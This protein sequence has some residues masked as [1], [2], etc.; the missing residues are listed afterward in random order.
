MNVFYCLVKKIRPFKYSHIS[1]FPIFFFHI[2][3]SI[4]PMN[5]EVLRQTELNFTYKVPF[6]NCPV[7]KFG[8]DKLKRGYCSIPV[9]ECLLYFWSVATVSMAIPLECIT[10]LSAPT[11]ET[12]SHRRAPKLD[13]VQMLTQQIAMLFHS[14]GEVRFSETATVHIQG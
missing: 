2:Y 5:W 13:A 1:S 8:Q 14:I 6:I 10:H 12:G 11:L 7:T 3:L 9:T 4:G